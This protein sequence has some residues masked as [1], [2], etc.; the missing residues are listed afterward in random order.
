MQL[1]T[2]LGELVVVATAVLGIVTA[3]TWA[4]AGMDR[5]R[6]ARQPR[7]PAAEWV[8]WTDRRGEVCRTEE[9]RPYRRQYA[10]DNY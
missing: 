2:V 7:R 5:T 6:I 10:R 1:L 9:R 8:C 4:L 3:V